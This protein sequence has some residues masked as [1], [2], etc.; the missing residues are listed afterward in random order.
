MQS[1]RRNC[2][3][4]KRGQKVY[5]GRSPIIQGVDGWMNWTGTRKGRE[6]PSLV[7]VETGKENGE[8]R[9]HFRWRLQELPVSGRALQPFSTSLMLLLY[10]SIHS[11]SVHYTLYNPFTIMYCPIFCKEF[12]RSFSSKSAIYIIYVYS[13]DI[14]NFLNCLKLFS[15]LVYFIC[16]YLVT[17]TRWHWLSTLIPNL[18]SNVPSKLCTMAEQ[19]GY[20]YR[21]DYLPLLKLSMKYFIVHSV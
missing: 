18:V 19:L 10:F 9:G 11:Q 3:Q 14:E 20:Y 5:R 7:R 6:N 16:S 15:Y 4:E 17:D 8:L 21:L 2:R 13:C 12:R 1:Y